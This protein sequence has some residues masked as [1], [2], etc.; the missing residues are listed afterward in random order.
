[1]IVF[2]GCSSEDHRSKMIGLEAFNE[3][4]GKK[5]SKALDEA[6]DSFDDFLT[7]NF[8][9][10]P[11]YADRALMFLLKLDSACQEGAVF[12]LDS[13]WVLN[14]DDKSL[15][16]LFEHSGL[17]S[18][19][20][21]YGYEEYT[22][23][24]DLSDFVDTSRHYYSMDTYSPIEVPND[25]ALIE[26]AK[27][28]S[29]IEEVGSDTIFRRLKA[30]WERRNN[31]LWTNHRGDFIYSLIKHSL[32]SSWTKSYALLNAENS[33]SVC[34]LIPSLIEFSGTKV[35]LS[36]P[37]IKRIIAVELYYSIVYVSLKEKK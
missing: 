10:Q 6:V 30:K 26:E 9:N 14:S 35:D 31:S 15:V 33:I 23:N 3:T 28:L 11:T 36:D 4:L 1:M 17:R 12:S 21:L 32:D 37:L 24:H 19:I 13:S 16:D 8:P 29:K 27:D 25:S 34:V 18:E 5:K 2:V 20:W 22:P 7:A